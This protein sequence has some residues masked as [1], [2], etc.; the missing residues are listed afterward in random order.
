LSTE[1]ALNG[2]IENEQGTFAT[3]RRIVG[4][5]AF[6]KTCPA[7]VSFHPSRFIGRGIGQLDG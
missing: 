2:D 1:L 6:A 5:A 4:R 3:R 7:K